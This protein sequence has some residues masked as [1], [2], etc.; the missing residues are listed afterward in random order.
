MTSPARL[1]VGFD[2]G[3]TKIAGGVIAADGRVIDR[4]EPIVTPAEQEAILAALVMATSTFRSRHPDISAVGVGT[5]GMV[6]HPQGFIRWAPNNGY[7]QMPLRDRLQSA[8]GLFAIVDNDANAAA[9]AEARL[10]RSARHMLFVTL[11]TGVGGGIIVEG[12]LLRG[13]TGVGGE[14]GHIIV[15]PRGTHRCGCGN[16]GCLEI[17]TSG[18]ALGRMGQEAAAVDPDGTLVRIAGSA[19]LVTGRTVFEAAKEGDPRAIALYEE[20]GEW[21]GIGLASLVAILDV[22]LI[23]VGGSVADAG[24]IL[25]E[26][27]RASLAR[28]LFGQGHRE[29]PEIV[30][31]T[32]GVDAGW[33]GAGLLA[34]DG[35]GLQLPVQAASA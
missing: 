14:I 5:A 13:A 16:I 27:T 35:A 18:N 12:G 10:G 9:W 33:M 22:P 2:I 4:L 31:A 25:F 24:E 28:H 20:L 30:A 17:L 6:D 15:D 3:G 26:P 34:L 1:A 11:G 23:V 8:T 32:H 21:L 19:D 29:L 7:H